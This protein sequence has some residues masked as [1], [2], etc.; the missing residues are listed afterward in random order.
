MQSREG[1]RD[2]CGPA[3][4]P[5]LRGFVDLLGDPAARPPSLWH[6]QEGNTLEAESSLEAVGVCIL[7]P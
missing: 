4:A 6:G 3:C 5:G 1:T 7:T 2:I